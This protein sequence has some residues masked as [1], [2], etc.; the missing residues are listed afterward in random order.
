MAKIN[1]NVGI[2]FLKG[3]NEKEHPEIRLFRSKDG[4]KGHVL[5]K[6]DKPK[7][8]T[9]QVYSNVWTYIMHKL[10]MFYCHTVKVCTYAIHKALMFSCILTWLHIGLMSYVY[11]WTHVSWNIY[12]FGDIVDSEL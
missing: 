4:K 11:A 8:I 10:L 3:E 9:I 2:Q 6:F 1:E 12:R 7:T 5:Y